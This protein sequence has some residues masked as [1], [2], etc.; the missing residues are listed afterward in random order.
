MHRGCVSDPRSTASDIV[1]LSQ[2]IGNMRITAAT[3]IGAKL[4][5][6]AGTPRIAPRHV[7]RAEEGL[8]YKA[9]GV[10]IEAGNE[11]VKRIQKLNPSIG[12]FSG[13]VPFG[14]SFLVA[15]TDGVGTKLKLAFDLNKH[16][17]V[18]IDLV[19]MSV[20]DIITSG[21]RPMFFLDYF[22]CGKLDVDTAEQVCS[23]VVPVALSLVGR[24]ILQCPPLI[25]RDGT[26]ECLL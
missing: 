17:T 1:V 20:N 2:R 16:D 12:G 25:D 15:G 3:P 26:I 24:H 7:V 5:A 10:D 23:S 4:R 13:M 22:A 11:L 21:A 18:G 6:G 8:S 19:A 14:D 9:A